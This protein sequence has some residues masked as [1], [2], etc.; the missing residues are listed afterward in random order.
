MTRK[1]ASLDA[2]LMR[3]AL[4]AASLGDPSPNPHVGAV[5][6]RG[7][8]IIAV[9]HHA[10]CGGPHAE[11][12]ALGRAGKRAR[13]ATLYVTFEPCNHYGRTPPCTEAI[14]ASGVKRVVIGC[15]DPAPHV[16]GSSDRLRKAGIEVVIGVEELRAERM[17]A[18][19]AKLMLRKLPH[20]TLKA[21]VTLDGRIAT[22]RGD[23]R[24]ITGEPARKE[25]HRM[26]AHA[27]AVLVGVGTVLADDPEL[28]VRHVRGRNPLRVVLDAALRTP[29]RAKLVRSA[30]QTRT[31]VFH[32]KGASA[33]RAK[34]LLEAGVELVAVR[35]S[36]PGKLALREV[37]R[38]LAKRDVMKLLVEG[39]SA[40]H[41]AFLEAG[42]ADRAHVF[43]APRILADDRALPLARGV[44]KA[45]A[46]IADALS[47][48]AVD[49]KRLGDDV[50]F[51]G[52]LVRTR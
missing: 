20:V 23:S 11:V 51:T 2:R 52:D 14:L 48:A 45:K 43:V 32:G 49:V 13:G 27:D 40:V 30:K 18:D 44:G 24:W 42:L 35:E 41:G 34:A 17:I 25:A 39:G 8:E 12:V 21:A 3:R 7:S 37:L 9:G 38:E 47:L 6:A 29:S 1:S 36:P 10:R 4:R 28:T 22:A 46:R 33:A 5:V 19:F 16:P 31:L 50:L 15:A 26:R